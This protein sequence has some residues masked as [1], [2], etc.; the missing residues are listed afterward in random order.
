MQRQPRIK[1]NRHLD[2]IRGLPCCICLN[3]T[4]TEAAHVRYADPRVGKRSTGMGEKAHDMFTVPLC[5]MHHRDQ[6]LNSE[7]EWWQTMQIDPVL[8]SLALYVNSGDQDMGETIV[9]ANSA[10]IGSE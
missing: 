6:H 8:L 2:F 5:G 7:R 3:N 1:D 4:A 9:S 10:R